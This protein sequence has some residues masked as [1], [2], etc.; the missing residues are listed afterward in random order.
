MTVTASCFVFWFSVK[1]LSQLESCHSEGPLTLFSEISPIAE[2]PG[3]GRVPEMQ[4][5]GELRLLPWHTDQNGPSLWAGQ[6]DAEMQAYL[7]ERKPSFSTF[8]CTS[9]SFEVDVLYILRPGTLSSHQTFP[10]ERI[11]SETADLG[12]FPSA[13]RWNTW[14]SHTARLWTRGLE[15]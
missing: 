4:Q 10:I 2:G 14:P 1:A 15:G 11:R 13:L 7:D 8:G 6:S 5:V 12:I 9:T 3:E